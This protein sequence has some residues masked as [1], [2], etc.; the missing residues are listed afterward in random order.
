MNDLVATS[1]ITIAADP[2]AVW[3]A[4]TDPTLIEKYYFGTTV[5]TDW[6]V[7]S[8]ISWTGEYEGKHYRDHGT[9]LEVQPGHVLVHTH[10]SPLGGRED[11]PENYH[12]LTY[13]LDS[14]GKGTRVTLSQ[15][16][17]D[18]YEGVKHSEENW[19]AM[20]EGLKKVVESS[21]L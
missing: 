10:F 16:N 17:N 14:K 4:L 3:Q 13:R 7:G 2:D 1:T 18:S 6:R 5:E 9:I 19:H 15:D 11:I 12:T 8:S 21:H 20:L